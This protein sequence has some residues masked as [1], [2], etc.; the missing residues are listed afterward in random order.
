MEELGES[1]FQL[2]VIV[3]PVSFGAFFL[4][5]LLIFVWNKKDYQLLIKALWYLI[6]GMGT[7]AQWAE[8]NMILGYIA[9]IEAYDLVFQY[10]DKRR[11]ERHI[12]KP[13]ETS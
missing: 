6:A 8:L 4:L 1:I 2:G 12:S 7:F 5:R 13:F 3:L 9:F 10:L 11:E